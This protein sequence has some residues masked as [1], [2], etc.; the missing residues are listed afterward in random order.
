MPYLARLAT[1]LH[2]FG[3]G[4]AVL[5]YLDM[6]DW[7]LA[8]LVIT[9]EEQAELSLLAQ[10]LGLSNE[11]VAAAHSRY[12]DE[13]AAAAERDGTVTQ[14][15]RALLSRVAEALGL[16]REAVDGFLTVA[17]EGPQLF[18]VSR[19]DRVCFTGSAT[20]PDGSE[21]TRAQLEALA[22]R[23]GLVPINSV[24]SKG[25]DLLVATDPL[26]QSGKAAKARKFGIPIT[27]VADFVAAIEEQSPAH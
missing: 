14:N 15:E 6:L 12:L 5:A 25:C 19:G 22:E 9:A 8:D 13:L 23:I 3:E 2:H 26:S 10:E 18:D 4:G 16:R 11:A 24:T 20:H 17:D 27:S 21:L 7:V 1:Q